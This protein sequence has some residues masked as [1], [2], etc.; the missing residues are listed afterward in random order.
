MTH[1]IKRCWMLSIGVWY[2]SEACT[3]QVTNSVT[4][5]GF[6]LSVFQES[7]LVHFCAV[8]TVQ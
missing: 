2:S 8:H 7:G 3:Q 6:Q 5:S 1:N 4:V